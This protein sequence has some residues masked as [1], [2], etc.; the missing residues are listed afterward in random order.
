MSKDKFRKQVIEFQKDT[1]VEWDNPAGKNVD[2]IKLAY[3]FADSVMEELKQS[4]EAQKKTYRTNLAESPYYRDD[5]AVPMEAIEALFQDKGDN[6][7]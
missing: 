5:E 4:L 6:R 7:E 3:K 2:M 1:I